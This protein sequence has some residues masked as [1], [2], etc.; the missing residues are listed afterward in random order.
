MAGSGGCKFVDHNLVAV[1]LKSANRSRF[2]SGEYIMSKSSDIER[3]H[4]MREEARLGGGLKRI[5]TQHKMNM[6]I[7][8][9]ES[10]RPFAPVVLEED[11]AD[12]FDFKDY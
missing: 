10:F 4:K 9:R 3:L 5:E 2:L 6:K 1:D 12:Y 7:K 8:F 11:V